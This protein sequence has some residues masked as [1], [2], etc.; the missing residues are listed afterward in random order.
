MNKGFILMYQRH[1]PIDRINLLHD[2]TQWLAL[3]NMVMNLLLV[4][5]GLLL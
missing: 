4:N 1:R 2:W 5:A 3:L